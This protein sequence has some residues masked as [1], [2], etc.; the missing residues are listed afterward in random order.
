MVMH[1]PAEILDQRFAKNGRPPHFRESN[2]MLE[3]V[4]AN[5]GKEL[6]QQGMRTT[7]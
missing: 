2:V 7:P 4:L 3:S 5:V 1:G 6:L